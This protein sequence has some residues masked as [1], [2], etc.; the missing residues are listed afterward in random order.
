M[1]SA[2]TRFHQAGAIVREGEISRAEAEDLATRLKRATMEV[3]RRVPRKRR[4]CLAERDGWRL[5]RKTRMQCESLEAAL[6][7]AN[8]EQERWWTAEAQ[9]KDKLREA[10]AELHRERRARKELE[11]TWKRQEEDDRRLLQTM[12]AEREKLHR[13]LAEAERDHET[14]ERGKMQQEKEWE[15][16]ERLQ[17]EW[18][19]TKED[20]E[21]SKGMK[22]KEWEER[23]RRIEAWEREKESWE[24][25]VMQKEDEWKERARQQKEWE[26]EAERWKG[27]KESVQAE[28][29]ELEARRAALKREEQAWEA[30]RTKLETDWKRKEQALEKREKE[31]DAAAKQLKTRQKEA[32]KKWREKEKTLDRA[33]EE[34]DKMRA[35]L[36]A[37][38]AALAATPEREHRSD[39]DGLAETNKEAGKARKPVAEDT[40]AATE[41]NKANE[42]KA[43]RTSARAERA[44]GT[45]EAELAERTHVAEVSQEGGEEEL[46]LSEPEERGTVEK[47]QDTPHKAVPS[48]KDRDEFEGHPTPSSLR[49]SARLAELRSTSTSQHA[50]AGAETVQAVEGTPAKATP[51]ATMVTDAAMRTPQPSKRTGASSHKE[52]KSQSWVSDDEGVPASKRPRRNRT[53]AEEAVHTPAP[54]QAKALEE[55]VSVTRP[56]QKRGRPRKVGKNT[57]QTT[58]QEPKKVKKAS[59]IPTKARK[60][61]SLDG[62]TDVQSRP[63]RTGKRT[64]GKKDKASAKAS[65]TR[66][67][68]EEPEQKAD[69]DSAQEGDPDTNGT[70]RSLRVPEAGTLESPTSTGTRRSARIRKRKEEAQSQEYILKRLE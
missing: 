29:E 59:T 41:T 44:N 5:T 13:K 63:T 62:S 31:A 54:H 1:A 42:D 11:E 23:E 56:A 25:S 3:R 9:W 58:E 52:E 28:R 18:E 61:K 43:P 38:E 60:K 12:E 47:Q 66:S 50:E 6:G 15:E 26:Q 46:L 68:K 34:V 7:E 57:S 40:Q 20:W 69:A 17:K 30:R 22:E 10:Q 4:T 33:R 49:R 16:K 19:R 39:S 21:R 70:K 36:Q 45:K 37:K 64:G 8:R 55:M 67:D 48:E 2:W 51:G 14:W 53:D 32:D 35:E 27:E 24:Q 65:G